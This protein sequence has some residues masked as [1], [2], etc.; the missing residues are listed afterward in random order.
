MQ[1]SE[2]LLYRLNF[3]DTS[4][5]FASKPLRTDEEFLTVLSSAT[6]KLHDTE[7][8][9]RASIYEWAVRDFHTDVVSE[10]QRTYATMMFARSTMSKLGPTVTPSGIEI[11][12]SESTPA[13][14]QNTLV[15]I[16]FKRHI[17]AVEYSSNL[18]QSDSW[19]RQ[20]EA[21]LSSAA[22]SEGFTSYVRLEAINLPEQLE[23]EISSLEKVTRIALTLRIPNPDIGPT[24]KRLYDKMNEASI[25]E[26]KQEMSNPAGMNT[27]TGFLP[28]ES[29]DMA[30]GGYREGKIT[31]NGVRN[32][33]EV[34]ISVGEA[35]DQ[36]AR[37]KVDGL[38][39]Y[40]AGFHDG[41]SNPEAKRIMRAVLKK[42][43]QVLK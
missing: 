2:V 27:Q 17:V 3:V 11:A 29:L 1:T 42:V 16:D 41:S 7:T 34:S 40:V 14:A 38:R 19:R 33:E 37:A 28:R 5:L 23:D 8:K 18:M 15:V 10:D 21:V 20:F 39:E 12:N 22:Q 13:L 32:G 6:Q 25:R 30:L 4:N 26:L 31:V 35:A 9:T 36:V 43:D 24:F